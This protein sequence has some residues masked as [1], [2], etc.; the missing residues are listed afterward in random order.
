MEHGWTQNYRTESGLSGSKML[1]PGRSAVQGLGL[2]EGG[3]LPDR[4]A[5]CLED[6][7]RT[8]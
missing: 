8:K 5:V 6:G 3:T 7:E 4:L 1:P 2:Q